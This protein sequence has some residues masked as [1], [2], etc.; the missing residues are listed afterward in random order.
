MNL[1]PWLVAALAGKYTPWATGALS[2]VAGLAWLVPLLQSG[3]PVEAK[4]VAAAVGFATIILHALSG[5]TSAKVT[6]AKA[7]TIPGAIDKVEAA[8]DARAIVK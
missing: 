8:V 6:I 1:P 7:A 5:S 4:D 2:T 3:H